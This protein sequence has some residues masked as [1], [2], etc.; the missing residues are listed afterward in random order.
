MSDAYRPE[1]H[2]SLDALLPALDAESGK[3]RRSRGEVASEVELSWL[4]S[5]GL[6]LLQVEKQLRMQ[7]VLAAMRD[8]D[9]S[10]LWERYVRFRTV[11]ELAEDHSVSTQAIYKRLKTARANFHVAFAEH[12]EAA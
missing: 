1:G 2:I 5:E 11:A 7:K 9:V 4:G 6:T 12:W 10:I 3:T 8:E